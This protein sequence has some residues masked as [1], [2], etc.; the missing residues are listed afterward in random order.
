MVVNNP[1]GTRRKVMV[2]IVRVGRIVKIIKIRMTI[3]MINLIIV[4]VRERKKRGR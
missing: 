1:E 4:L 2:I 3:I